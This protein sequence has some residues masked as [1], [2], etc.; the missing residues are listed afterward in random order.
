MCLIC[1]RIDRIKSRTNP[2]FVKELETG[3]VV[4]GDHQHFKGY[5]IF[6]CKKHVTELHD[7]PKDFRDK[8]LSEMADVSQAVSAAFSAEKMNIESLGNGDIH[9]H[10]HLFPR[11]T[12]DLG[13]HGCKGKGPVWWLPFEEMYAVKAS[14]SE[15]EKLKD[16][17]LQHLPK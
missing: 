11:K 6:L 15:I 1:E 10:W 2:Y 12:G 9:L 16:Q 4:V 5:T 3:Y 17:L 13:N 8:H 7:L 14:S